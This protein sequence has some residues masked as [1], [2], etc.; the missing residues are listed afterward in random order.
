[1]KGVYDA[2]KKLCNKKPRHIDMVRDRDG[3]LSTEDHE[4]RKRWGE[5]FDEVLN[6]LVPNSEAD[7]DDETECIDG[8]EIGC[9]TRAEIR[10]ALHKMKKGKAAGIDSITIELYTYIH[11]CFIYTR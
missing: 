7:M 6:R 10:N 5:H 8:I 2:T 4:I 9:I 1:M 3:N 11:T